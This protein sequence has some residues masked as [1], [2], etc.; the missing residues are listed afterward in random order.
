MQK[1][2]KI[3]QAMTHA[4]DRETIVETLWDGRTT[5]PAGLQ[6]SYYGDMFLSD[7]T[8]PEYDME[9]AKKLVQESGY[10]GEENHLPR[11]STTT[12]PTRSRPRRSTRNRSARSVST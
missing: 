9:L 3:R 10:N 2:A 4:I 5:V 6:W 7:W 1:N 8:V 11:F 12:T